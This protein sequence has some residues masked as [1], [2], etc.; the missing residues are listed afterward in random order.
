MHVY[1]F[2]DQYRITYLGTSIVF[3]DHGVVF[4]PRKFIPLQLELPGEFP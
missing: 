1:P 3:V 4:I 2:K